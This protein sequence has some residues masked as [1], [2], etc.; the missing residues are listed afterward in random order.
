MK[1]VRRSIKVKRYL[2]IL[3]SFIMICLSGCSTI[4]KSEDEKF[5]LSMEN[6]PVTKISNDINLSIDPRI[7]LISVII[8]LSPNYNESI[9]SILPFNS[10]YKKEVD[11]WFGDYKHHEA[12]KLFDSMLEFGFSYDAPPTGMLFLTNT[13]SLKLREDIDKEDYMYKQCMDRAGGEKSFLKFLKALQDFCNESNFYEFYNNHKEYYGKII[14]NAIKSSG[15]LNYIS[16]TESYYGVKQNSY[17]IILSGLL[18]ANNY[19]EAIKDTNENVDIFCI[20]G[21][22]GIVDDIPYFGGRDEF[23][24]LVRHEFSHSFVNNITEKNIDKVNEYKELL[25]PIKDK[26]DEQAYNKW[27]TCLNEHLVRAVVIRLTEIYDGMDKSLNLI[28][29]ES[30][31]GFIYIRELT[32]LLKNEYEPNR[33]KYP[34]FEDFYPE[35]LNLLKEL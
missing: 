15:N 18:Y 9:L 16:Q 33:D 3:L 14:D 27:E 21:S 32:N 34:T 26:M 2:V 17:N 23:A 5:E 35:I 4:N 28:D 8:Y 19:G 20:R 6:K 31:R 7:E 11:E 29:I 12:V 1:F 22:S 30:Q 25:A 13:P 24:F 10:S